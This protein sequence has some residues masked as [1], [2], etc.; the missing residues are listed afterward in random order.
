MR[1]ITGRTVLFGMVGFFGLI[2]GVN[3]VMAY[4]AVTTF[5]GLEVQNSYDASQGYDAARDA[6]LALGWSVAADYDD[7][8]LHIAFTNDDGSPAKV[9]ELTALVGWAT[10]TH[11]DFTPD[12]RYADG[13]F[14]APAEMEP[15]NWNIRLTAVAADGTIFRQRLPLHVKP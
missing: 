4:Y 11:D 14:S 2:I 10:S 1:E 3:L 6:Q 9:S 15:G 8:R 5:S 12:F 13:V 7:G